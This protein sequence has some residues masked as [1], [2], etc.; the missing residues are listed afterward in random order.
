MFA[1]LPSALALT[2]RRSFCKCAAARPTIVDVNVEV[3][4]CRPPSDRSP[5][6]QF[7]PRRV[8]LTCEHASATLPAGYGWHSSALTCGD[9][10][11]EAEEQDGAAAAAGDGDEI[12]P[13]PRNTHWCARPPAVLC[14]SH[15][16]H[17]LRY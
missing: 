2:R 10:G 8:M 12:D 1:R 6:G 11:A 7:R 3:A 16:I 13:W 15:V 17:Q 14:I 9:E 5:T 4:D